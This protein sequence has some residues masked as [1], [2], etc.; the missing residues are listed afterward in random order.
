MG[1]IRLVEALQV[2]IS[3][4]DHCRNLAHTSLEAAC[5]EEADINIEAIE[6]TCQY[7]GRCGRW[8]DFIANHHR[9]DCSCGSSK[10]LE[11]VLPAAG[12]SEIS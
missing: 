5:G 1:G 11:S 7:I 12:L 4:L 6:T 3:S 8:Q 10:V 9:R 2:H